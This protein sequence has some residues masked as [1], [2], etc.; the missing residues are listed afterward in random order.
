V[1]ESEE[2]SRD[3]TT[4]GDVYL[5]RHLL[6]AA[7]VEGQYTSMNMYSMQYSMKYGKYENMKIYL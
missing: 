2:D 4:I 5:K 3:S 7:F 1:E 6:I